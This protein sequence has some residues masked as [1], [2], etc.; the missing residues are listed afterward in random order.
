MIKNISNLGSIINQSEQKKISGGKVSG[1][2]SDRIIC[3]SGSTI[4]FNVFPE[5]SADYLKY[6]SWCLEAG[7]STIGP[8]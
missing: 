2:F 4:I 8:Q 3:W 5:T 1:P 7:G 6:A